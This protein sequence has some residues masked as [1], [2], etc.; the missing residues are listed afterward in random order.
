MYAKVL[1]S[2]KKRKCVGVL[3]YGMEKIYIHENKEKK[4]KLIL[5]K[6]KRVGSKRIH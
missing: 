2:A 3:A 1:T 6:R 5:N 4:T